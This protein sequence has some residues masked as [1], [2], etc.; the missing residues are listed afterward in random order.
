MN[1]SPRRVPPLPH[2]RPA[3]AELE[4]KTFNAMLEPSDGMSL[5]LM[6]LNLHTVQ[7]W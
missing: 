1:R 3:S 6:M 2:N 7:G 5:P 4:P